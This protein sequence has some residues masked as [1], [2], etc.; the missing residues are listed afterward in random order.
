[1]KWKNLAKALRK[2]QQLRQIS[3][4]AQPSYST[5]VPSPRMDATDTLKLQQLK[6]YLFKREVLIILEE[7]EEG[8][9]RN[10]FKLLDELALHELPAPG[11]KYLIEFK[12][13]FT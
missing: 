11:A 6:D 7:E 4:E 5:D 8:M 10:I 2:L 12:S 9:T 3:T 13:F 1:M